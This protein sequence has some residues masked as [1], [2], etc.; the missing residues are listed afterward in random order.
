[1]AVCPRVH[2][3]NGNATMHSAFIVD[4]LV[5]VNNIK[6]LIVVQ[7]HFYGEFISPATRERPLVFVQSARY[8]CLIL[9]KFG[10]PR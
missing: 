8:F 3:C 9:T 10:I 6:I 5:T 7:K 4:L 2:C 1:M